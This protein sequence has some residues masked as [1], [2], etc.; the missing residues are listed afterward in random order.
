MLLITIEENLIML[1]TPLH[2]LYL[3]SRIFIWFIFGTKGLWSFLVT[4][5][6]NSAAGFVRKDQLNTS[7]WCFFWFSSCQ[8]I[9]Q[10]LFSVCFL[11]SSADGIR[12][13]W[14]RQYHSLFFHLKQTKNCQ[15]HLELSGL[16]TFNWRLLIT[17]FNVCDMRALSRDC[18]NVVQNVL[19]CLPFVQSPGESLC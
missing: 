2:Y 15:C 8:P 17:S 4:L 18:N 19:V 7:V 3:F 16:I 10:V 5:P 13:C 14:R 12:K 11:C 9:Q 1:P 6:F